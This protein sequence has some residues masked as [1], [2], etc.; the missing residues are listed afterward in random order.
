MWRIVIGLGVVMVRFSRILWRGLFLLCIS[1]LPIASASA[2]TI[3]ID[4][5]K[6]TSIYSQASFGNTPITI[7]ILSSATIYDA[8][9]LNLTS[10]TDV[11]TLFGLGPDNAASRIVDAFFVDSIGACGGPGSSIVGCAD[12]PGHDLVVNSSYA[13]TDTNEVDLGHELGHNFGLMHVAGIDTDLM[14]PALYGSTYLSPTQAA[15]V[16]ASNLVQ[17]AQDGSLFV[18]IRPILVSASATAGPTP[19]GGSGTAGNPSVAT[20]P[21]PAGLPLFA[22]GIS[23]LGLLSRRKRRK[24]V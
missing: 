12:R 19:G 16:L 2:A 3:S 24:Q 22:T 13:A 17:T 21:L 7:N 18:N 11:S 20:T 14:N 8:N 5:A 1:A 4:G 6:L 10:D 9:L 15:V 23:F